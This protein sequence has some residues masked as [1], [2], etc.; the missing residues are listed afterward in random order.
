MPRHAPVP[1]CGL[2][3]RPPIVSRRA[4]PTQ[5]MRRLVAGGRNRDSELPADG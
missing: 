5:G 4:A 1:A 3:M 2:L